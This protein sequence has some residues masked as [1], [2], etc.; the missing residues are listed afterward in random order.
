MPLRIGSFFLE[1]SLV[2]L[3]P[4][5]YGIDISW[6]NHIN[7]L[8]FG[9]TRQNPFVR[10]ILENRT[11]TKIAAPTKGCDHGT[12]VR[13]KDNTNNNMPRHKGETWH[14]HK[15]NSKVRRL[16]TKAQELLRRCLQGVNDARM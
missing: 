10:L 16:N 14:N 1:Q 7:S 13:K 2:G 4:H 12:S 15:N 3:N 11:K 6:H 9:E 5:P 8:V